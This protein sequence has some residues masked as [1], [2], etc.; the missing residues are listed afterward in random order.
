MSK[1]IV[2]ID[3]NAFFVRA[4][5]IKD[6]SLIGKAVAIGHNGRAGIVS[7]C[8][9]KAREYG[10]RSGMPMNKAVKLCPNLLIIPGDYRFYAALSYEFKYFIRTYTKLVE[11]ASVDEVYADFT[12]VVKGIDDVEG[13][14]KKLQE[15]LYEKTELKCS[16]GIGPTKFLAKMGSDYKK[17]MGITI[18]RRKDIKK[19]LYPIPIG[20]M[21]GI[22][23]KTAPRLISIGINTIGDL[24]DRLN[25]ND[26]ETLNVLGK[27]STVLKDWINGYGEDEIITEYDDPKSIG[28]ST[29]LKEDTNNLDIIGET[30]EMLSQEVSMRAK[31]DHLMGTTIQI[32]AKDTNYQ[33]HNKSITFDTPTND[34]SFIARQ[35]I[36][37]YEKN[38][39]NMLVRAVGVT[40]QNL[41]SPK[42]L[43][44]QM[45]FF[46]YEMH[47]EE[48]RTKLIINDI[49]RKIG[50]NVV[51][52]ASEVKRK[53]K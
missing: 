28:N 34:Q 9:Y 13:F 45:T 36:K 3:L 25:N 52:R 23:K 26:E 29:T 4:E 37:L 18:I 17:P 39:S 11:S 38:Y 48:N 10:V 2:H 14:F 15:D 49:N 30:F 7:T 50:S 12:N 20:D 32:M 41:T 22:G 27:F 46:D 31:R 44:I 5:E 35:A 19:I 8:S 33:A 51:T 1:V 24:A 16:I 43:A 42:D 21:Y 6:P 40:L 47:E 53:K